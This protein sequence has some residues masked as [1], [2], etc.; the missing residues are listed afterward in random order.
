MAIPLGTTGRQ[1]E[2]IARWLLAC[3]VVVVV[4]AWP[5]PSL[6]GWGTLS[7]ALAAV[8][9][10]WLAQ[11]VLA[12]DYQ[13]P[14]HGFH[15][16]LLALAA[17]LVGHFVWHHLQ[18]TQA[19]HSASPSVLDLSL[20]TW[21]GIVA[22]SVMLSQ[23]LLPRAA[24]HVAVLSVCGL[25][26][27]AGPAVAMLSNPSAGPM[28]LSL[29][30]L[31][32]AGLAVWLTALWG[33]GRSNDARQVARP[34]G[35][36][37]LRLGIAAVALGAA[38]V[39]AWLAPRSAV[40]AAGMLGGTLILTSI[41]LH[42]RRVLL[43]LAG[44]LLLVGAVA[45]GM[46]LG[47]AARVPAGMTWLGEG[48]GAFVVAGL[49]AGPVVLARA[50]GWFGS[51]WLV[52][53]LTMGLLWL[54]FHA[55]RR[56]S[57]D[58]ARAAL[59]SWATAT[60]TAALLTT[61]GPFTP[62]MAVA[63]GFTWGLAPRVLGRPARTVPGAALLVVLA[64][65]LLGLAMA[66]TMGLVGWSVEAVVRAEAVDVWMHV[67]AGLLL[68]LMVAWLLDRW[69]GWAGVIG[70]VI[71]AGAGAVGELLQALG[72]PGR[73]PQWEDW[74]AHA[75]GAAAALVI[76]V[77]CVAARWCESPDARPAGDPAEACG[78]DPA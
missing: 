1:V 12:R 27:T 75:I 54:L 72:A 68:A 14:A 15:W 74:T 44:G 45:G 69:G 16:A 47:L 22:L 38:T 32:Y 51:I 70:V 53:V 56:R 60:A 59:W 5:T 11:R 77:L 61:G 35:S 2:T 66:R 10:L 21:M 31:G 49:G 24:R 19:E 57:G 18:G 62:A 34:V 48:G 20:L 67:V 37:P 25:A 42:R 73:K 13:V 6:A 39:L 78:A 50:V 30:L 8:L 7:A 17:L 4:V 33:I 28:R 29:G 3:G 43:G 46:W 65:A 64:M 55:G 41:A 26:M 36:W 76:Y 40:V 63:V 9:V 58:M 23:S 52:G 71:A